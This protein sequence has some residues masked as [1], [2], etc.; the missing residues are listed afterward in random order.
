MEL[1]D[2]TFIVFGI[3]HYNPLGIIRSLG[4]NGIHPIFICIP[5]RAKVASS[6][7]YISKLYTVRDYEEGCKLLLKEFANYPKD[8]LPI[9]ITSDDEQVGYMDEHYNDYVGKFIFFNAGKAGKI[10]KYMDKFNILEI[11]KKYGLSTLP[12]VS[13]KRG[14]IPNDIPFPVIT[15]SIAPNIGGWKSDVHICENADQLAEA[16]KTIKAPE[17]LIQ[18]YLE[19]KNEMVLEGFSSNHGKDF[20]VSIVSFYKY[21]IKGYY[22]PYHDYK[23]FNNKDIYEKLH[24]IV[25]EI[26]FEGIFEI[27]FLVGPDDELYFS[28]IN[29]RNSTWSYA[30]TMAGMNLPLL[31]AQ[32][33]I[34]G[35]IPKDAYK[36]IPDGMTAIVEPIDYQKR[37][38]ER[39]YSLDAWYEDFINANC[40]YYFNKDDLKPFFVMLEENNNL[41]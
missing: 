27:E 4:E 1:K 19:K 25:E 16:Y 37:V 31:W 26:G 32:S 9:V 24:K 28:E 29:F 39:G 18:H 38:V 22:S 40:K 12:A 20:F 17:V 14:I 7:K 21:N 23:N 6:S 34:E 36:E 2:R 35:R 11:A 5:G 13:V 15:K 10:T 41:R 30:S 3:D 33:M 8:N